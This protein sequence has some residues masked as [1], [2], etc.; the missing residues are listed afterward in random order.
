MWDWYYNQV[1]QD[2]L[3]RVDKGYQAFF[4]RVKSGETPG[5][6]KFKKKG[7]WDSIT[8]PQD[9]NRP[10]DSNLTVPKV[11][12]LNLPNGAAAKSELNKSISDVG[13]Y[14]F[15]QI[16]TY[17][18][19]KLGK[20]VLKVAAHY[21]SQDC[22]ACGTRVK[23]S[24]STRTHRCPDCGY[25]ANRNFNAAQNILGLGLQSLGVNP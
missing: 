10:L 5:F 12:V 22:S 18:A 11:G 14:T 25:I 20:K 2:V 23:K 19:I 24:L 17:K 1:L 9:S 13:W 3:K 6:P 15:V 7:Q 4:R 21:T 8:Y 16:L